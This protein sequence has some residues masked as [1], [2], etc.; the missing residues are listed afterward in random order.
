[1][2]CSLTNLLKLSIW[3]IMKRHQQFKRT[4]GG[5]I[6]VW[7]SAVQGYE[8]GILGKREVNALPLPSPQL[9]LVILYVYFSRLIKNEWGG[10]S[11][12]TVVI[13]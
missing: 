9:P 4:R 5:R 11:T 8:P 10:A 12:P 7:V 3:T 1:M 2:K 13:Y 6:L